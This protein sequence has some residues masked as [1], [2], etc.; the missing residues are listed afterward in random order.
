MSDM[1][2]RRGADGA[3]PAFLWE[4]GEIGKCGATLCGIDL[5]SRFGIGPISPLM[6]TQSALDWRLCRTPGPV[7]C[8]A[9]SEA[10][11]PVMSV[12]EWP[13]QM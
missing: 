6:V 8:S 11:W 3:S 13:S 9:G 12:F 1:M 2:K 10:S 7:P 5:L 4:N